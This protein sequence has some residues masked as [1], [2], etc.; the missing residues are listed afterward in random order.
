M[1][2]TPS[3]AFTV[4]AS[5]ALVFVAL[6]TTIFVVCPGNVSTKSE[7]V[8]ASVTLSAPD[9]VRVAAPVLKLQVLAVAP[10]GVAAGAVT[11]AGLP[12][13]AVPEKTQAVR[14]ALPTVALAL[15]TTGCGVFRSGAAAF[16]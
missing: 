2:V 16:P 14:G 7:S 10:A 13:I 3:A 4:S 6:G 9:V 5:A 15:V 11:K 12:V 8:A 1:S